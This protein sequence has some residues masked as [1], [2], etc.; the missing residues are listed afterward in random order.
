LEKK[1]ALQPKGCEKIITCF[2]MAMETQPEKHK[3]A[4]DGKNAFNSC[5][6]Q[7]G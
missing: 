1:F 7:L 5:N 6:S 2:A 3:I 4:L